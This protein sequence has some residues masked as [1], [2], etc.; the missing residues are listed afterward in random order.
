MSVFI[1]TPFSW[2]EFLDAERAAAIVRV[3]ALAAA[4]GFALR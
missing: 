1:G 4:P 2:F 3:D